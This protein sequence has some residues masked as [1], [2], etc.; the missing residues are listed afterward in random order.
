MDRVIASVLKR[1]PLIV[2]FMGICYRPGNTA[3]VILDDGTLVDATSLFQGCAASCQGCGNVVTDVMVGIRDDF[4]EAG[5]P[6]AVCVSGF[7]DD[8]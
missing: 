5:I 2:G 1:C 3:K 7:L 6:S 8:S 4:A